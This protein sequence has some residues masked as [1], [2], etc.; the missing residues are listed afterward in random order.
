MTI[1]M[2]FILWAI[3]V[4][5]G[6][7]LGY[8][9]AYSRKKGENLATHEDIG[10][11]VDQV[12]AVTTA[13]KEIEEKISNE[14]WDRQRRWELK[15][16]AV[17]EAVK[18]LCVMDDALMTVHTTFTVASAPTETDPSRWTEYKSAALDKWSLAMRS[19]EHTSELQSLRHLVCRLL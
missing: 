6:L 8:L 17:F 7:F 2:A 12:R 14:M 18:Q 15:R 1:V 3:G 19:E 4:L 10:K 5:I 11:L 9:M 16:D 13:T